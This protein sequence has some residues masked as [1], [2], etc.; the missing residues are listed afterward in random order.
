MASYRSSLDIRGRLAGEDVESAQRQ[1]DLSIG[2]LKIGDALVAQ[3][4]RA[5]ALSSYIKSVAI[6]RAATR[7]NDGVS[8]RNLIFS[9][10]RAASVLIQSGQPGEAISYLDELSQL[11]PDDPSVYFDRGRAELYSDQIQAANDDLAKAIALKTNDPYFVIWLHIGRQRAHLND[12]QELIGNAD[13]LNRA[14]WPWPIVALLIGTAD[15][16]AVDEIAQSG[17]SPRVRLERTCE[18]DFYLG[19]YDLD[20]NANDDASKLFQSAAISCPRDFLEQSAARLELARSAG[21]TRS[22]VSP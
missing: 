6:A 1:N 19:T 7:E 13:A 2:Y 15:P 18:A 8:T 17:R 9:L 3:G 21:A 20:R 4:K 10:T 11:A 22:S 14:K 5:D 16:K 12:S